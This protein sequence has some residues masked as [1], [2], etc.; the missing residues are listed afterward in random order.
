MFSSHIPKT[1]QN[2]LRH[3]GTEKMA[4]SSYHDQGPP[5][6]FPINSNNRKIASARGTMGRGKRRP[7]RSLFLKKEKC[8]TRQ[9]TSS[10]TKKL[11]RP[12]VFNIHPQ[13]T[14]I[15]YNTIIYLT[16]WAQVLHSFE[17]VITKATTASPK[18]WFVT[19]NH[20]VSTLKWFP[21]QGQD[22]S[23]VCSRLFLWTSVFLVKIIASRQSK[24]FVWGQNFAYIWPEQ[25]NTWSRLQ[26][27][28][29]KN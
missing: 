5:W 23:N 24:E 22:A 9:V 4:I 18:Y 21:C 16:T 28:K 1:T 15:Q 19:S 17:F 8:E 7:P 12:V 10:A 2:R 29:W 25:R 27:E 13:S 6:G 14:T 20:L 11:L 3:A 26:K